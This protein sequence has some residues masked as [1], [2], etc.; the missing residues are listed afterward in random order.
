MEEQSRYYTCR[1]NRGFCPKFKW[2][3]PMFE[4]INIK[5][6]GNALQKNI[7]TNRI[8]KH[9]RRWCGGGRIRRLTLNSVGFE[10]SYPFSLHRHNFG[11]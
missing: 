4:N 10:E 6:C 9:M 1:G 7:C 3:K 2:Q 5:T 11:F 8:I